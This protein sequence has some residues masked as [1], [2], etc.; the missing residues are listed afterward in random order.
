MFEYQEATGIEVE[1]WEKES[2]M[3]IVMMAGRGPGDVASLHKDWI[4]DT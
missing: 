3:W 1:P 2:A 4:S